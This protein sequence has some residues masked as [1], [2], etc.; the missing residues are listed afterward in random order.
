M[1]IEKHYYVYLAAAG[2]ANMKAAPFFKKQED[3]EDYAKRYASTNKG[4]EPIIY[5]AISSARAPVPD[6]DIVPVK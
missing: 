6:V 3:A 5:Q 1:A 2:A 4:Y